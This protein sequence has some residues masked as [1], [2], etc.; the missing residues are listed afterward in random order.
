MKRIGRWLLFLAALTF[1]SNSAANSSRLT[2]V[3]EILDLPTDAETN[4]PLYLPRLGRYFIEL[5]LEPPEDGKN[6][7]FEPFDVSVLV[8]FLQGDE[9]IFERKV[10]VQFTPKKTRSYVALCRNA[11]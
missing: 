6:A 9:N 5:Y 4:I 1:S 10:V 7:S 2:L 11:V 3:S 8:S